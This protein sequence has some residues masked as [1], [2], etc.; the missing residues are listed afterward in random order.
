MKRVLLLLLALLVIGAGAAQW[1]FHAWTA[2]GPA[3]T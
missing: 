1:Y 2:P 3:A